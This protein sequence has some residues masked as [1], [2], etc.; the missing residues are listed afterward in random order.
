VVKTAGGELKWLVDGRNG[1]WV[2]ETGGGTSKQVV[3]GWD[4]NSLEK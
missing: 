2:V 4:G 1:W 3:G